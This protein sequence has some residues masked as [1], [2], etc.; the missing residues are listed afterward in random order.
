MKSVKHSKKFVEIS[1]LNNRKSLFVKLV[2][3]KI[4]KYVINIIP[5][6]VEYFVATLI[7]LSISIKYA[8]NAVTLISP[9]GATGLAQPNYS[10]HQK[11]CEK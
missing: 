5:V 2:L 3:G 11:L 6:S 10:K 4:Q 1:T 7:L 9:I 8:P